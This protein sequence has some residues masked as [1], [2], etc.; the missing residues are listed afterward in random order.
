MNKPELY[1][2]ANN[3]QRN[4]ADDISDEF[5]EVIRKMSGRC[6]DIGSGPGDVVMDF[7]LPKLNPNATIVCSDISEAVVKFGKDTYRGN[8]RVNFVKLDI[9]T[10]NL[11]RNLVGQFDHVTSFYCLHW[12]QDMRQVFDNIY[13]LLQPGGTSL[14]V[15]AANH[16][17]LDAYKVLAATTCYK[18]YMTDADRYI[19]FYQ[20]TDQQRKTLKTLLKEVGFE[21]CHCSRRE[22]SYVFDKLEEL[23]QYMLAVD[24]FIDRMPMDLRDEY[25]KDLV[26][27][28]ARQQ[29]IFN[30]NPSNE[31]IYSVLSIYYLFVVHIR[32][33]L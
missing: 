11:S 2:K 17:S 20:H 24:S 14:L 6:L 15:F 19:P 8:S 29:F 4:D 25:K 7:I 23:S 21:V 22:K 26:K 3:P 12:C 32:K 16:P 33:P 10:P 30:Q 27:E 5:E 13:N 9:Q 31:D 18:P 28:V 1:V